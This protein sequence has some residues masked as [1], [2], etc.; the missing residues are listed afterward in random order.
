MSNKIGMCG[1]DF[2]EFSETA[3]HDLETLFL[4]FG[5]S[6]IKKHA[7]KEIEYFHQHDIHF[8]LN[9]EK[10][11][12]SIEFAKKHGPSISSMGWRFKDPQAAFELAL[13]RGAKP[14]QGDLFNI[15]GLPVPA[16][17]G[18]GEMLIYF[19]KET[20]HMNGYDR[21]GF[22][23]HPQPV[24]N[25][26]KGFLSMDHLTNNV[27]RGTMQNWAKFYQEV[28]EF[29][30]VR[31][32]DIR[33]AKTGLTSF[34]L[35][36]PCES[37]CIPINEGTEKQSQINEYLEKYKGPGVQHLAFLTQDILSSLEALRNSNIETLDIDEQYYS[38]IFEKFP[39]VKEDHQK[40]RHHNVLV[41]GDDKGYLLQ[42]FTKDIIGPIFIEIIQRNNHLSFGEGNFGALFRSIERDQMKRGYLA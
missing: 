26:D 24:K 6:K 13:S 35:R 32:F 34:A 7:T 1:F 39:Q 23:D 31:Y 38:E 14:A 40:I 36:S 19:M 25:L 3:S 8:F 42:I 10:T 15:D 27:F 33:G 9:K 5:F 28:F 11:G 20:D 17:Y 30:Q 22:K 4:K 18:L 37:F 29:S 21:L 12:V 2:V 41:D 16:V